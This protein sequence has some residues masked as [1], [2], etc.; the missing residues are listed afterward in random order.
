MN[1]S[2]A[3]FKTSIRHFKTMASNTAPT[4]IILCGQ[5]EQIGS[6]VIAGIKPDFESE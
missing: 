3:I 2:L 6:A 4:P 1:R 5:T